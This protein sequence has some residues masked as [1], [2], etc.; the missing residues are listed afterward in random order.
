MFL[1]E[2]GDIGVYVHDQSGQEKLLRSLGKGNVVG[3]LALLDGQPRS[4]RAQAQSPVR[5][6]ML[7]RSLFNMFIQSRPQ[8]VMAVL[9]YLAGKARYTTDSIETS[10]SWMKRIGQGDYSMLPET[11]A[12]SALSSAVTQE[13][14][15]VEAEVTFEPTDISEDTPSVI[16][17]IFSKVASVLQQRENGIR[18]KIVS[19]ES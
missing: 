18:A 4:A 17:S 10:V 7:S 6:L 13:A 14:S 11:P 2:D 1:I 15:V 12:A 5:L 19:K 16:G 8:V 9:Q 3:E